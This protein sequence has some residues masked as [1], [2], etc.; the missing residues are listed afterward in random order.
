VWWVRAQLPRL[1][2][3]ADQGCAASVAALLC[4]GEA[5]LC[6]LII[7]RVKYTEIDWEA[8]VCG[9]TLLVAKLFRS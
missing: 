8:R 3:P 6:G 5:V 1:L 2:D 4:L 9:S 7:W